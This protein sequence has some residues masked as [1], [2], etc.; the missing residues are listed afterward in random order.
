[1]PMGF[2]QRR[3]SSSQHLLHDIA[4][5]V[6]QAEVSAAVTVG[7]PLVVQPQTMQD[8][9]VQVMDMLDFPSRE[10]KS[11]RRGM[12]EPAPRTNYRDG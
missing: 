2:R 8:G 1:M 4:V 12:K 5:Y 3:E 9:R 7:Q 11:R 10:M 6:G